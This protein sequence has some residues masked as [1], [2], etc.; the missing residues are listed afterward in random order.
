MEEFAIVVLVIMLGGGVLL[1]G[2][3]IA[4]TTGSARSERIR[5][6][7]QEQ[8]DLGQRL[9]QAHQRIGALEQA[10][11]DAMRRLAAMRS[12]WRA[13]PPRAE[14][15]IADRPAESPPAAAPPVPPPVAA[16]P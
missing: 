3:I 6:L 2:L 1:V 13:L 5:R 4:V 16:P 10:M 9:H 11:G 12:E 15:P 8:W 14:A 7:E